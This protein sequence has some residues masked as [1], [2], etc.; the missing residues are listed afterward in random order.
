LIL[1]LRSKL[2]N[3]ISYWLQMKIYLEKERNRTA[4][5]KFCR[6]YI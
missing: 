3:L 2:D 4:C 5:S 6:F 1:C